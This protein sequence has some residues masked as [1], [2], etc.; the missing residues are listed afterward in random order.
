M[1]I[2]LVLSTRTLISSHADSEKAEYSG[3]CC[4]RKKKLAAPKKSSVAPNHPKTEVKKEAKKDC[5]SI[6]PTQQCPKANSGTTLSIIFLRTTQCEKKKWEELERN[7][8]TWNTHINQKIYEEKG[9]KTTVLY[10]ADA[11]LD[12]DLLGTIEI[13]N[14]GKK[15]TSA[16]DKPVQV[17]T[18]SISLNVEGIKNQKKGDAIIS[19]INDLPGILRSFIG[20]DTMQQFYR[21][22]VG[23]IF[24]SLT[25][26]IVQQKITGKSAVITTDQ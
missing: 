20:R 26:G 13:N 15:T 18:G 22:Q 2:C 21:E 11:F 7:F 10:I 3:I 24:E 23:E 16:F 6:A 19:S 25:K 14:K 9:A 17:I 12:L 8:H 5:V 1:I 4:W